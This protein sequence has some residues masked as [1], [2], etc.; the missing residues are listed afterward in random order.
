MR[1]SHRTYGT[2][3]D[4]IHKS[5]LLTIAGPYACPK[6]FALD[7]L[8]PERDIADA[9]ERALLGTATHAVIAALL[10]SE[11]APHTDIQLLER[12]LRQWLGGATVDPELVRE[13]AEMLAGLFARG[14][15]KHIARVLG[16]EV[17]FIA[18]FGPYWL[19]GHVDLVY[20]PRT[21]P[22]TVALADWKTG[23]TKPHPLDLE[24]G[25]EA[26]IYS[27]AL[28]HGYFMPAAGRDRHELEA[29]LIDHARVHGV[30]PT[31]GVFPSRVYHVHLA[32]YVPYRKTGT[33]QVHRVEDL[34]HYGYP[35]ACR[36]T[37][38]PGEMR[39]G[40]WIPVALREGDLRR[41]AWRLRNVVGAVRLGR[42]FDMPGEQC[43]RCR[44]RQPCLND[45]YAEYTAEEQT[46]LW[47]EYGKDVT[48]DDN[49]NRK[50]G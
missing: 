16:C 25:W 43:G 31:Y 12:D 3:T 15:S 7:R 4:P 14:L 36:H 24:H 22:G 17:G 46:Q 29:A 6:R 41:F 49:A 48:G 34:D 45:G 19:S 35:S 10:D 32:D 38:R 44:H 28:R 30:A 18:P 26:G 11:R 47:S 9:H 27:A 37:Y 13:R 2:L 1:W 20:E 21:L 42:M 23:A 5:H 8:T 33:K 40:A 50:A 39:G